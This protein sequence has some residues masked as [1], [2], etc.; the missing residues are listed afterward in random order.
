MICILGYSGTGK[1]EFA[2]RLVESHGAIQTGLA[3]PAKR[4]MADVYGFTEHQLFGP[5]EAR[6]SGD[7]RYPK[8]SIDELGLVPSGACP[9]GPDGFVGKL[10][11]GVHYWEYN[12]RGTIEDAGLPYL[13]RKLGEATIYVPEGHPKFWLSPREALQK[14][15]ELMNMMYLDTWIR[16]GIEIHRQLATIHD[17]DTK[18]IFM[19]YRYERMRGVI[20]NDWNE[21]NWRP[22]DGRFITCFADFRHWHEIRL[23]RESSGNGLKTILVRVKRPGIDKPP[24]NHRSETEQATIPD[25]EF[26]F[27]VDNNSD[28]PALHG[29][30]DEIVRSAFS[31]LSS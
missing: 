31:E 16:K 15:C 23:A 3:D 4:H 7:L 28:I 19:L 22:F 2:K 30:A 17:Q 18:Q 1:D 5:S 27:V 20:Q 10:K 26:D 13:P 24:F 14:Y 9:P 25:S 8:A 6:N 21:E 12:H 29:K 11:S